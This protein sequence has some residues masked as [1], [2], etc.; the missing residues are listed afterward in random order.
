VSHKLHETK[1][2]SAEE[3][4]DAL[5]GLSDEMVSD[6]AYTDAVNHGRR[7]AGAPRDDADP[8]IDVWIGHVRKYADDVPDR[9]AEDLAK[10][11]T[12]EDD[13]DTA[14]QDV[15][16]AFDAKL[17]AIRSSIT[18]YAEPTWGAGHNGYGSQ[19][20]SKN[21]LMI[22]VL[23]DGS[24]HCADCPALADGSPYEHLPT[25]PGMGETQCMDRCKC[26]VTADPESWD[27]SLGDSDA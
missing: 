6:R 18:R 24:E 2:W 26:T 25:W 7:A 5:D 3:F 20:E 27:A 1:A 13:G 10:T 17:E 19:L 11:L 16:D 21:V 9:I 12:D 23:D 14:V 15:L 22:W 4:G 8:A